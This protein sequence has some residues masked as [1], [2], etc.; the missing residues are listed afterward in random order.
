MPSGGLP[1]AKEL[2]RSMS[3]HW[4][5]AFLSDGERA[6][7]GQRCVDELA[8]RGYLVV[9]HNVLQ[10]VLEQLIALIDD[11]AAAW[12]IAEDLNRGCTT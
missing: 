4:S 12:R 3:E 1:S 11:K 8:S 5:S 9:R 10:D 6:A 7:L 2:N